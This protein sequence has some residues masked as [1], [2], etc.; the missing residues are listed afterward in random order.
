MIAFALEPMPLLQPGGET[1]LRAGEEV[2]VVRAS[3]GYQQGEQVLNHYGFHCVADSFV[4]YGY[5]NPTMDC[6]TCPSKKGLAL[7]MGPFDEDSGEEHH[8]LK[9]P[10]RGIWTNW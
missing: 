4:R 3:V 2:V 5:S 10:N 1:S 7:L 9:I 8:R 6:C